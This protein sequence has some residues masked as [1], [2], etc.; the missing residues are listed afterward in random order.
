MCHNKATVAETLLGP[1]L[2]VCVGVGVAVGVCG[3]GGGPIV[4]GVFT[5]KDQICQDKMSNFLHH[6]STRN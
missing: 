1:G 5:K 6:K 2:G 3:D 4:V